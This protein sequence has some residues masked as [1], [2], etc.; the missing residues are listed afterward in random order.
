MPLSPNFQFVAPTKEQMNLPDYAGSLA[1]GLEA[2]FM[3][4]V[5]STDLL[6][7]MLEAKYKQF[8]TTPEY[9]N[10]M[11]NYLQ[12]RGMLE[13]AMA[14]GYLNPLQKMTAEAN[15]RTQTEEDLARQ[16]EARSLEQEVPD[17]ERNIANAQRLKEI[18][19][20]HPEYF[21][22]TSP[23]PFVSRFTGPAARA[24]G[25][26][27]NE[28]EFGEFNAKLGPFVAEAA[29]Q[30]SSRPLA[31]ALN[32]AIGNK[33]SFEMQQQAALGN[34]ESMLQNLYRG[35][36]EAAK[37]YEE[38]SGK[39]LPASS[40]SKYIKPEKKSQQSDSEAGIRKAMEGVPKGKVRLYKDGKPYLIPVELAN[41]FLLQKGASVSGE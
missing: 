32:Q 7:K 5:K 33:P 38:L 20:A 28:P 1:R 2:G 25:K 4:A 35:R 29:R 10:A 13:S 24:R 16:K 41:K 39:K 6:N 8:K 30:F 15:I 11:L 12:G 36:E 21:G 34:L 9:Q 31:L 37:R 26:Y 17:F 27:G 18:A 14:Q 3:P 19:E 23:L 22:P 40:Y